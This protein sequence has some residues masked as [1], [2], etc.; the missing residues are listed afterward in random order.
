MVKIVLTCGQG[1]LTMYHHNETSK[2]MANQLNSEALDKLTLDE[3]KQY[4]LRYFFLRDG[5]IDVLNYK[6]HGNGPEFNSGE[7]LDKE[8]DQYIKEMETSKW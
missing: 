7:E 2:T 8:I 5:W 1:W 3:I 6:D 4:A